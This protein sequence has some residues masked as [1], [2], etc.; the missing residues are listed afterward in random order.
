MTAVL[1]GLLSAVANAVGGELSKGLTLRFPA[2]QLIGPLFF[3]NA[4]LVVPA[5]PFVEWTWSAE[6]VVIHLVSVGLLVMTSL[7]IWDLYDH[8]SAAA[9]V[10]AQSI[11]PLPAAMAVAVLLPGTLQPF[12]AV[13]AVIVVLAVLLGL[14]DSF[15]ALSRRRSMVTVLV[16]SVGTGLVTVMGR[17]LADRDVGVVEAYLVRAGLAAIV[18][19]L[20]VPPRDVPLRALPGMLPRAAFITAHFLLILIGVQDGSPAVVQ[21]AVATAPLFSL[22]IE[23]AV[24]GRRPSGRLVAAAVLAT[25]GVALI[26]LTA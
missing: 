21:T 6:I 5:A 25:I 8:G 15:G 26:L 20:L 7:A 13:A 22:G 14:S 17:L 19:S 10:T 16:A 4:L 1:F 3:L 2:R 9:T 24:T 12:Q 11:S 18:C 23:T